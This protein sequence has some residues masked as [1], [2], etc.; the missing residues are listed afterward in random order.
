M[1]ERPDGRDGVMMN[2]VYHRDCSRSHEALIKVVVF[3]LLHA[4]DLKFIEVKYPSRKATRRDKSLSIRSS[5][6]LL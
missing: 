2:T 3:I 6:A 5:T 1:G 4:V